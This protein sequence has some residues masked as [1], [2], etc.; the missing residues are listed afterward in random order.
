MA[1][2]T[3]RK[4]VPYNTIKLG[5]DVAQWSIYEI[6]S[7]DNSSYGS[8]IGMADISMADMQRAAGSNIDPNDGRVNNGLLSPMR[9][10]VA[11]NTDISSGDGVY[12]SQ[13]ISTNPFVGTRNYN[14]S[15]NPSNI[16]LSRMA[17]WDYTA[18]VTPVDMDE[19]DFY[20]GGSSIWV[21]TSAY[22]MEL[23]TDQQ[24][25]GFGVK[26]NGNNSTR[27]PLILRSNKTGDKFSTYPKLILLLGPMLRI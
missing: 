9:Y 27:R 11:I 24:L 21:Q 1:H 15:S 13:A 16:K 2:T 6:T 3:F 20:N 12:T 7:A 26:Q 17:S 4:S 18:V 10:G 19:M 5:G 25:W 22:G 23:F 8:V 14:L